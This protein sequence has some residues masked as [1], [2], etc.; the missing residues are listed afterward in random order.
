[1]PAEKC[2]KDRNN[3]I[4]AKRNFFK[5]FRESNNVSQTPY[6]IGIKVMQMICLAC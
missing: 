1:M 3:H 4:A 5:T 6:D 2:G